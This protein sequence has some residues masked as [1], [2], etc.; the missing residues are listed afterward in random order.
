M[1]RRRHGYV[2]LQRK[3]VVRASASSTQVK[4]TAVA[5]VS[6]GTFVSSNS[7]CVCLLP[8]GPSSSGQVRTLEDH[9][10]QVTALRRFSFFS[11]LGRW[12]QTRRV[13]RGQR[14]S[15]GLWTSKLMVSVHNLLQETLLVLKPAATCRSQQRRGRL[16]LPRLQS[17]VRRPGARR[18]PAAQRHQVH[19]SSHVSIRQPSLPGLDPDCVTFTDSGSPTGFTTWTPSPTTC[20]AAWACTGRCRCCWPTGPTEPW[21]SSG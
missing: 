21:A 4:H 2:Q 20:T 13:H 1:A 18:R 9:L 7:S 3:A 14:R 6:G 15:R 12:Q 8:R 17:R 16:P 10:P 11:S 19:A 5:S